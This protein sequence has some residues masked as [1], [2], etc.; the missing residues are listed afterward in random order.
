MKTKIS[1]SLI[2]IITIIFSYG[3]V[4]GHYQIFP[5]E[6]L[7]DFN[8]IIQ[9][10][11]TQSELRPQI[12]Q[13][14][15]QVNDLIIIYSEDDIETKK[16]LLNNYLW[17]NNDSPFSKMPDS[18]SI[19]IQDKLFSNI[20]SLL[21]INSYTVEMDYGMNSISYLFLPKISNNDLI[22]YHQGH[23]SSS[24]RGYDSHSFEQD[25]EIIKN[26]LDNNY[27]VLIFSMPGQGMN[28]EPV[29]EISNLGKITLNSHDHFKLIESETL[30]PIKFFID[31]VIITLN[32]MEKN[33]NFESFNMIGLSGGGWSTI[34]ISALDDRIQKSYSV[35]GSFPIWMRSDP[36]NF[37]DYEQ[38]VP[39]FYKIANYEEL[40]IMS[41][42]GQD[43]ELILFYNEFD[44]CCFSGE[45]YKKFP[46]KNII[47]EKLQSLE[48]GEFDVIIDSEQNEHII[49]DF[50][51]NKILSSLNFK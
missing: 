8:Q 10:K 6:I 3:V 26:F 40:Y 39:E 38:T 25:K 43:R 29:V 35:A 48:K 1:I 42:Y 9:N 21:Q 19:N 17:P 20:D 32:H 51:F 24:L 16:R 18:Y 22:I 13:D 50:T 12:Y 49:S 30:R 31:P 15:S 44:P 7:S 41:S 28:N 37:G 36:S 27:S 11:N 23:T 45:L 33:H 46:F 5:F 2:F 34:I 14:L 4:V 47:Q